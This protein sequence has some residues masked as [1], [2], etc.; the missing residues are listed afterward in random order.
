MP[1]GVRVIER[2]VDNAGVRLATRDHGGDGPPLVLMHGAGASQG[3]LDR[4]VSHLLPS[5]RVVTF[6]F[7][8]HGGSDHVAWTFADSVHDL[9]AVIA[10]YELGSP[11]VGGHSL[12]GMVA[13]LYGADHADCPGAV[14]VDGHGMGR[15]EQYV[16]YSEGEVQAFWDDH[17]RAVRKLVNGRL[18]AVVDR[19]ARLR[20]RTMPSRAS[21]MQVMDEVDALDLLGLYERVQC[22]LLLFNANKP[23]EAPGLMK[24]VIGKG[25]PL[26]RAYRLGLARDLDALAARKPNVRVVTEPL[27][28]MLIT[29]HPD[30]V[31]RHIKDFLT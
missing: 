27:T 28:H 21:T 29:T 22:P 16:G 4:V 6:D 13:A 17:R 11:A 20:K 23:Q 5:Y 24:L 30:V 10:A 7:R 1:Y 9:E 31:A 2:V 12:G 18:V 26:I 3:S 19:I 14:N 8:G 25:V 15:V